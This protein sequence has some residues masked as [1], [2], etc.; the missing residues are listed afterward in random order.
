MEKQMQKKWYPLFLLVL[1]LCAGM[2]CGAYALGADNTD[3]TEKE[4]PRIDI[5]HATVEQLTQLS[6]IGN[7]VAQR[8]VDYRE[9]NGP[10]QSV[11]EIIAVR[12]I[13]EKVFE[14]IKDHIT[15]KEKKKGKENR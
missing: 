4:L 15:V 11:D 12:G 13:G 9:Q 3:P 2:T 6:R 5:N 1:V 14:Q 8:I 10:F 7:V